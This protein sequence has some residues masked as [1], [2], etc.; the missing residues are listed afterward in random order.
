VVAEDSNLPGRAGAIPVR[1][2]RTREPRGTAVIVYY[3]GGGF[4]VGGLH[5][6]DSICAEICAGSGHDVIAVDYRLAPEHV[7]P[8]HYE[9]A[10]WA[11]RAIA[12]AGAPVVVAGDSAGGNLAAAVALSERGQELAPIGQLLIYPGLGGETLGLKSYSENAEA[13]HLTARDIDFYKRIRAGGEPPDADPTYAPLA[14][15]SFAGIAPCVVLTADIDPLRDDG[16]E[17][18]R[19]L[20]AADVPA[21][22]INEPGLVHGY[23]RAREMSARARA[24]FQRICEA[25]GRLCRREPLA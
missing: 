13:V 2:Y 12:K 25:A 3:H 4:V 15:R 9:D 10:L 19:R 17:Y 6:H 11:F 18:V 14:A 5:S 22:W 24:S 20:T 1:R 23:L 7:H 8:A 16:E 21:R